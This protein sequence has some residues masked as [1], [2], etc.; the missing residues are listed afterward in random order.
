[1]DNAFFALLFLI[2]LVILIELSQR[3]PLATRD[4]RVW[5]DEVERRLNAGLPPGKGR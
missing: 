1:M 4:V 2:S 3:P 5:T